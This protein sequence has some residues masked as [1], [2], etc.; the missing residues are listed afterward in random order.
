MSSM[1]VFTPC[2][3]IHSSSS[4]AFIFDGPAS[5]IHLTHDCRPFLTRPLEHTRFHSTRILNTAHIVHVT[6]NIGKRA[7]T[8]A[9]S[10]HPRT[11]RTH[12]PVARVDSVSAARRI[13]EAEGGGRLCGGH[14]LGGWA[15]MVHREGCAAGGA[16]HSMESTMDGMWTRRGFGVEVGVAAMAALRRGGRARGCDCWCGVRGWTSR[17]DPSFNT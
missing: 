11:I 16:G 2:P 17:Q 3:D 1:Y 9:A 13:S 15:V 10:N 14:G 5:R 7:P 12:A 4:F 6:E 8:T